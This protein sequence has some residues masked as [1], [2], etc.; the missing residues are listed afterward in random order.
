M[1]FILK[2][3]GDC[4]WQWGKSSLWNQIQ[5]GFFDIVM[6]VCLV[7]IYKDSFSSDKAVSSKQSANNFENDEVT[8]NLQNSKNQK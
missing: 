3:V 8:Q 5:Q 6:L 7:L 4:L 1:I 2:V